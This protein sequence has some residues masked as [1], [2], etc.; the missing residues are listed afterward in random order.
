[1]P[2]KSPER[3]AT[4][5]ALVVRP[6]GLKVPR[7]HMVSHESGPGCRASPILTP[8]PLTGEEDK[9]KT[10]TLIPWPKTNADTID[11]G[12][13]IVQDP[14]FPCTLRG[15]KTKR[16]HKAV[17]HLGSKTQRLVETTQRNELGF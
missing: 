2:Q 13:P 14:L 15:T 7:L 3:S 1:M 6:L 5:S 16:I 17:L 8:C 10:Y 12:H 11:G 4:I 9:T